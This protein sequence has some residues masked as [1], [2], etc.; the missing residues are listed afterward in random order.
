MDENKKELQNI[1]D[2]FKLAENLKTELRHSWTSN[3]E[4]R[5]SVAEHTWMALLVALTLIDKVEKEL[6]SNKVF[7]MLIIHDLVEVFAKD[8]PS[9]EISQRQDE[10]QDNEREALKKIVTTLSSKEAENIVN[11]WEE[12]EARETDEAKFS[13]ALDKFECLLQ[14]NIADIKTWDEGDFRYTFIERQDTPFN[15]NSFM[16]KLKDNLDDWTYDK[17]KEAEA[18]DK[19]PEEN[20]IRYR[21]RVRS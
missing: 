8:I 1:F 15:Y 3:S 18:I 13:Y 20:L 9:H 17:I 16:R 6:D 19:I 7:R 14:H 5:E 2:F 12:F 11:L 10:K 4:R 21:N